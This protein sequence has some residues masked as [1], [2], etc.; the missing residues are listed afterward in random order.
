LAAGTVVKDLTIVKTLSA[1]LVSVSL[2]AAAPA[3]A[4]K[5]DLSTVTCKQ[6]VESSKET[7]SLIMMWLA[8]FYTDED[9]P[10]IVDFDKVRADTQKL[11]EYCGKNPT[12]GLITAV[13]QALDSVPLPPTGLRAPMSP[14]VRPRAAAS[15]SSRRRSGTRRSRAPRSLRAP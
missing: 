4:Q 8:G 2:F 12:T 7:I 3:Q 9:D 13:E 1:V 14:P 15:R 5:L 10:P 6:F 11:T